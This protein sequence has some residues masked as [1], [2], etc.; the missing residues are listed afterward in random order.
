MTK[1][2][3]TAV[4]TALR[5]GSSR[6]RAVDYLRVSTEEQAEAYGIVYTGKRTAKRIKSKGWDHVGTYTDEGRSGSLE[7]HDRPDLARLMADVRKSPRPFDIVVVNGGRVIGRTGPAFWRWV[8]ALEEMGVFVAVVDGDFDNST[9]EGRGRM[10]DAAS[11]VERE[12]ELIRER[13]QGGIQE[14]AED[15]GHVGG[16]APFGWRIKGK[17]KRGESRLGLDKAAAKTL[18]TAWGL[19]VTERRNRREAGAIL[20]AKGLYGPGG[21]HWSGDTLT[22]PESTDDLEPKSAFAQFSGH[23]E[24]LCVFTSQVKIDYRPKSRLTWGDVDIPP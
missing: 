8:W 2:L 11:Y 22:Q 9:D 1:T 3:T 14:K 6:L 21:R 4:E 12:R 18:R 19:I 16:R 13:T 7:A 24:P 5:S 10:R 23:F 17:G 15:G 20:N